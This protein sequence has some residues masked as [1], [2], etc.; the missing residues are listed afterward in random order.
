MSTMRSVV[1][2]AMGEPSEVLQLQMSSVP[3]PGP[4]QVRIRVTAV[5]VH[6]SDL[7]T[8]RGRYGFVPEF[9]TTPGI[10]SVGVIDEIGSEV[11]GLAVGQRVITAGVRGTWQEYLVA[12]A[13]RVL[14]VPAGMSDSTA[15][16]VLSNPLTAVILTGEVL[17]VQPGEWLLQTAAGSTVGQSVI[18]LGTHFGFKTLNV[19]RRRSAVDDIRALG[20]T[21]V[22]STEDEDLRARVAEI[23]GGEGVFKA[24]DSVSGQ[25]GAD[26]SRALAPG[27][28]LVVYGAL[29]THRQTEAD[30]LTIPVFARSLIYETKT[31]RGFWLFRWF[32]QTPKERMT[33]TINKTIQLLDSGVLRVP[34]GQP[35]PVEN[36]SDAVRLA[37]APAHGGKPLLVFES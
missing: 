25:V 19:V 26:V 9:P 21:A 32:N 23:A 33:A 24:I 22:I 34:E 12:D 3:Q 1:A 5:P 20:G 10:E 17:D 15:A 37:E 30:K 16:Q 11:D 6:A 28:E 4:R 35:V 31:V 29:S 8:V 36:F 2:G 13:E 27:G 7:H 18:Q 14:P